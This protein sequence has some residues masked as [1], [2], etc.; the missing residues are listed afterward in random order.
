[1]L[2]FIPSI[3]ILQ[4]ITIAMVL[5]APADPANWGWLRLAIPVLIAGL[6]TAATIRY[7]RCL[8]G[9]PWYCAQDAA[10]TPASLAE[11]E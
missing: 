10:R 5:I 6:L 8:K 7:V 2:K 11:S 1:M 9:R 4:A 3:L